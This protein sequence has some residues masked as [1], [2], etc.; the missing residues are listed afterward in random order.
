MTVKFEV[1][2]NKVF[3][4]SGDRSSELDDG[5]L[6][7]DTKGLKYEG[8]KVSIEEVEKER[9]F[10]LLFARVELGDG[11]IVQIN[12]FRPKRKKKAKRTSTLL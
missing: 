7:V 1:T 5:K 10:S 4:K 8:K 12:W 6:I 3:L 11:S 9:S 2:G